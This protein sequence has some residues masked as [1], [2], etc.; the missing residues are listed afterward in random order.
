MSSIIMDNALEALKG[1]SMSIGKAA[2]QFSVPETT[3]REHARRQKIDVQ[4]VCFEDIRH[5]VRWVF[6]QTFLKF[7]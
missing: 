4:P 5:M 2:R 3:L 1:G 7:I 6:K